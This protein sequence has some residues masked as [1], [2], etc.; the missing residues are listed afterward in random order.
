MK[1]NS[2]DLDICSVN[3]IS[4]GGGYGESIVIHLGNRDFIV[5][6]SCVD[7]KTG[8]AL[9][10]LFLEENNIDFSRVKR[11]ICTHWHKD[12][13][14][15]MPQ[16]V[17]K[18]QD[19]DFVFA[20]ANNKKK[21]YDFVTLD[22][23]NKERFENSTT[24][25]FVKCLDSL[26]NKA[27]RWRASYDQILYSDVYK[28]QRIAI[29]ALSPSEKV[30]EDYEIELSGL[31]DQASKSDIRTPLLSPNDKSVVLLIEI[32]YHNV[33]LGADLEVKDND[34]YGWLNITRYSNIVNGANKST[35]FKIPHH[36]S[37]NGFHQEI[38]DKL[39]EKDPIASITPYSKSSLPKQ[40]M[41]HKYHNLT[42]SLHLTSSPKK[43]N[44]PKKRDSQITKA[45]LRF[46]PTV[47]EL[48]KS[49]GIVSHTIDITA[50]NAEWKSQH[51]GEAFEISLAS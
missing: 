24:S 40:D 10:L 50:K 23:E 26:S 44:R 15:G 35:Y 29:S 38:W 1:I 14:N 4:Q 48:R 7:K 45:I 42:K 8:K 39:L 34:L 28:S 3:I 12:H 22:S 27:R 2:F 21:F 51:I 37:E 49:L 41:L 16:I 25:D 36:G 31:I 20:R 11:I 47:K 18:C 32:G 5:I 46:N 33:L 13:I 30:N 19:A 6:D 17:E 9:P 43:F